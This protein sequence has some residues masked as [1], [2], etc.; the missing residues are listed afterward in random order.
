[1]WEAIGDCKYENCSVMVEGKGDGK[2]GLWVPGSM[3]WNASSGRVWGCEGRQL[4]Q[5]ILNG[6][7]PV[8]LDGGTK[9][10]GLLAR[11]SGSLGGWWIS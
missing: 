5:S 9:L 2:G 11:I 3:G 10:C 1:M 8:M 7:L 4:Q 6:E